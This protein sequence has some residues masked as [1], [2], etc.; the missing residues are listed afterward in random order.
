MKVIYEKMKNL[1]VTLGDKAKAII[2]GIREKAKD[3]WQRI[4]DLLVDKEEK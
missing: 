2:D 4:L 3:Y 1:K